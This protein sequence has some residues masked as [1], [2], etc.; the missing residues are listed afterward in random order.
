MRQCGL[1]RTFRTP[2]DTRRTLC[3]FPGPVPALA[4]LG[5][6]VDAATLWRD[7]QAVVPGLAPDPQAK[8]PLWIEVDETWLSISGAKH[9]V[10]VV[11]G[12]TGERLD[13]RLSG[14]GFDWG[15]WFTDL[16]E[17]GVQCRG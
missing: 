17:R 16:A 1:A 6:G 10:T 4:L 7:V 2:I 9:P 14:P 11:L 8:L 12:P 3:Q 13:L 5:C 15:G